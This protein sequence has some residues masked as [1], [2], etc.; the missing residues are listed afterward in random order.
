[1]V[2]LLLSARFTRFT[3]R[4]TIQWKTHPSADVWPNQ[5]WQC[6]IQVGGFNNP[7]EKYARRFGSFPPIFGMEIQKIF[8]TTTQIVMLVSGVVIHLF[9]YQSN[10]WVPFFSL[11]ASK[12]NQ[13]T[14]QQFYS[15]EPQKNPGSLTDFHWIPGGLRSRDPNI[16]T[17]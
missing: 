9:V 4:K 6:S 3:A 8:E 16:S 11:S 10:K 7:F 13:P 1:M 17:I 14:N 15:P 5:K 12:T 2:Y